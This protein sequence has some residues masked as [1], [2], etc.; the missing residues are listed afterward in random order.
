MMSIQ[1]IRKQM[2]SIKKTSQITNAMALVSTTKY[3][4]IVETSSHYQLYAQQLEEIVQHLVS[5]VRN[6]ED[7]QELE[8]DWDER[9][10]L[11]N[12]KDFLTNRKV[13]D[14]GYMVITS[15]KGLAGS[16]NSQII[17]RFEEITKER[18][19]STDDFVVFAI[20]EPIVKYCKE[21]N[22]QIAHELH[23]LPD[24]PTY[25]QVQ[26]IVQKSV[27]LFKDGT[28]DQLDL[29]YN[30]SKNALQTEV[31]VHQMLPLKGPDIEHVEVSTD[32]YLLEPNLTEVLEILIPMYAE[33][34]IYGSI[35]DAKTA[36]Q[37]SRMQAM[38]QATD[39]A[40]EIIDHLN[41]EYNQQRQIK[42]T[43][44]IIEVINGASAQE[45]GR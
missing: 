9:F 32:E 27:E 7:A 35:I 31:Y 38:K 21:N 17:K 6:L 41:H 34:F 16:Y 11:I 25:T 44:E 37:G 28:Y 23:N 30:H 43:N 13:K 36:E 24:Y 22:I 20:G 2:D 12:F 33:S 4:S 10:R 29:I 1:E 42:I 19:D 40:E 18:H 3:N 39:N 26:K 45:S 5:H 15:D 14:V 8:V